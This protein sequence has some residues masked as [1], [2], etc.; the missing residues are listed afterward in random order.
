MTRIT[1]AAL[2]ASVLLI[3]TASSGARADLDVLELFE[4]RYT[5]A[6]GEPEEARL[7]DAI[8]SVVDRL[9][10]F[11]RDIARG[12]IRRNIQPD[13]RI[14][15]EVVD[16][17]RLRLSFGDWGPI[18]VRLDGSTTHVQGPDGAE[19]RIS[20]RLQGSRIEVIQESSRGRRVNWLT[21][22]PDARYLFLQVS[23]GADQLPANI[24][25]TLSYRRR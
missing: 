14:R 20:A 10:F 13:P 1:T 24:R 8:D 4:G 12:E 22:S 17:G 16:R 9:S 15:L 19:T 3:S 2:A 23:V 18:D 25:Y 5:F 7:R 21:L 6:G 11:I